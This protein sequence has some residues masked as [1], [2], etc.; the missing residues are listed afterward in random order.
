MCNG[1]M[2][3]HSLSNR[4]AGALTLVQNC[5]LQEDHIF[6]SRDR[7]SICKGHCQQQGGML[8]RK[9]SF[10]GT[11]CCEWVCATCRHAV[12]SDAARVYMLMGYVPGGELFSHLQKAP[13]RRFTAAAAQ[14][15]AASV[16]LALE[17]LHDKHIV[18]RCSIHSLCAPAAQCSIAYSLALVVVLNPNT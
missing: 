16:L 17:Y 15:Y 12:Y 10:S 2:S 1:R 13:R 6:L 11:R 9:T 5:G 8:E 14:F 3:T 18:Y 7:G 4:V